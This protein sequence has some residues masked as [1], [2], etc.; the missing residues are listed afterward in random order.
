MAGIATTEISLER[1]L[2]TAER[3][4]PEEKMILRNKILS[5]GEEH[6]RRL[7]EQANRELNPNGRFPTTPSGFPIVQVTLEQVEEELN[8]YEARFGLSSEEFYER[9]LKGE[10]GD[11]DEVMRW[12]RTYRGYLILST[13]EMKKGSTHAVPE[14][15]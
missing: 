10:M 3:L 6:F 1:I 4:S 2:E 5:W 14:C 12:A 9:Y 8:E 13:Q 7:A 11:S 15:G